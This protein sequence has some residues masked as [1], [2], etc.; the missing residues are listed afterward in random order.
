MGI[1]TKTMMVLVTLFTT[2]DTDA[3]YGEASASVWSCVLP[4]FVIAFIP[5]AI[6]WRGCRQGG[7]K[8]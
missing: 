7:T 4:A 2:G 3:F 1:E 8:G 5:S 6:S